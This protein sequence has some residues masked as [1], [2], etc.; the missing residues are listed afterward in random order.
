MISLRTMNT[1]NRFWFESLG[2]YCLWLYL[3]SPLILYPI[4]N[5]SVRVLEPL[6]IMNLVTSFIWITFLHHVAPRPLF[7]HL[8]LFPLYITTSID[9]FLIITFGQRLSSGYMMIALTNHTDSLD[10]FIT[11]A[12]PI[13]LLIFAS[14]AFYLLGLFAI[15]KVKITPKRTVVLS[16]AACLL[17]IYSIIFIYCFQN[18]GRYKFIDSLPRAT[19]YFLQ[20]EMGS[21]MGSIFQSGLTLIVNNN[22][23]KNMQ[24]RQGFKFNASQKKHINYLAPNHQGPSELYV[25]VIGESSRPQNWSLWGYP[26]ETTPYLNKQDG[27]IGFPKMLATAPLTSYAVPSMLS[28][29][30]INLWSKILA[31]KS[32]VS[33]FN[34][35]G[36]ETHWLSIQ[37]VDPWGGAI[38]IDCFRSNASKVFSSII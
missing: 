5:H 18:S 13:S 33:I 10:F 36:F 31:E 8:I 4:L 15:R 12:W 24:L 38:S 21:P 26:R 16:L 2:L 30:P 9:L 20:K 11:Y 22:N 34:E 19:Y 1:K 6:F 27:I 3:V 28:L 14:L 25:W 35:V 7:L 32:I 37:D 29:R 17:G 23:K